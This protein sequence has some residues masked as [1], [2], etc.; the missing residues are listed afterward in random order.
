MAS[1]KNIRINGILYDLLGTSGGDSSSSDIDITVLSTSNQTLNVQ[2]VWP[3]S[4]LAGSKVNVAIPVLEITLTPAIGF[5]SGYITINGIS[6]NK[7]TYSINAVNDLI[8]GATDAV[9][10]A[11]KPL[12]F[13][14]VYKQ[15]ANSHAYVTLNDNSDIV[16]DVYYNYENDITTAEK[17]ERG[18]RIGL[19]RAERPSLYVWSDNLNCNSTTTPT[20]LLTSYIKVAGNI[21]GLVDFTSNTSRKLEGLFYGQTS[22]CDISELDMSEVVEFYASKHVDSILRNMF[23]GT[24]ITKACELPSKTV[25]SFAYAGMFMNCTSLVE[26]P[27]E[28]PAETTVDACYYQMFQGCTSLTKSP[29]IQAKTDSIYS[30][31]QMFYSCSSLNSI[32]CMMTNVDRNGAKVDKLGWINWVTGVSST[33]TFTKKYESQWDVGSSGIPKG[34]TV[35]EE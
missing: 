3:S 4:I 12:I 16:G 29:K 1:I 7:T 8:I 33:G 30:L 24:S 34:W 31:M 32:E 9:A 26:P 2:V 13:S 28:L 15:G 19:D 23:A 20:F 35:L 21:S 17:M 22:L 27:S 14:Y 10:H 5:E 11:K 18:V 25:W 6:T